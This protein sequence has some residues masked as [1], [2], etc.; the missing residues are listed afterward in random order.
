V[1][2]AQ[3]GVGCLPPKEINCRQV[4]A[5]DEHSRRPKVISKEAKSSR[6]PML[7]GSTTFALGLPRRALVVVARILPNPALTGI[8]SIGSY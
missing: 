6:M 5:R 2:F 3:D 1:E 4:V 7:S 8:D